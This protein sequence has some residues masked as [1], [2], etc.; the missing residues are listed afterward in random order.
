MGTRGYLYTLRPGGH[1]RLSK[2]ELRSWCSPF[3]LK[4][5]FGHSL[6][7]SSLLLLLNLLWD[8]VEVKIRNNL[9]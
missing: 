3:V 1:L 4:C 2:G 7:N 9:P 6:L 8:S 5:L